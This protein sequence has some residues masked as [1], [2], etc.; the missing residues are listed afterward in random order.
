MP[1]QSQPL[2]DPQ[3]VIPTPYP[4]KAP[5]GPQASI[6]PPQHVQDRMFAFPDVMRGQLALEV[7]R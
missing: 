1:D 3:T 7:S 2:S 6:L 4:P 5:N